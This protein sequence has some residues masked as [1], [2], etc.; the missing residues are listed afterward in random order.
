MQDA[1]NGGGDIMSKEVCGVGG[2]MRTSQREKVRAS[3][4]KDIYGSPGE[5]I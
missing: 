1:D 3:Q 2:A 5:N 4:M